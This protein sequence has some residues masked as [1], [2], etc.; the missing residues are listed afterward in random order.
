MLV[1]NIGVQSWLGSR[2]CILGIES[3]ID[4]SD[5]CSADGGT[6][7]MDGVSDA[8]PIIIVA[9]T[10]LLITFSLKLLGIQYRR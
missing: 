10:V 3:V 4:D 8:D 6:G 2:Q 9:G 7:E 5:G 1:T